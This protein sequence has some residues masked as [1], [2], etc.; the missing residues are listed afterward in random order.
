MDKFDS[1][2]SGYGRYVF[3]P[4]FG[5]AQEGERH[6]D[7]AV[8]RDIVQKYHMPCGTSSGDRRTDL[9]RFGY[10]GDV[11]VNNLSVYMAGALTRAGY[12]NS[13]IVHG[14]GKVQ[15]AVE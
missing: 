8:M 9:W 6:E 1:V 12:S 11:A 14:E 5:K 10:S 13:R 15:E 7:C 2:L 3:V 4:V